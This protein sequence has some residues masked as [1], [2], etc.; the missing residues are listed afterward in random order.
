MV[1]L[2]SQIEEA[3][4]AVGD[5]RAKNVELLNLIFPPDVAR[6]LWAGRVTLVNEK[7]TR[8]FFL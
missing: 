7:V 4:S 2:K 3:S 1:H 6:K 5:E 8:N